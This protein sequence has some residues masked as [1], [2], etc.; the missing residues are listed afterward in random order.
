MTK[1]R[2]KLIMV[3]LKPIE[4]IFIELVFEMLKL[5]DQRTLCT[6]RRQFSL[7]TERVCYF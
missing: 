3:K 1:V 6:L 5:D 2:E 7:R 4:V